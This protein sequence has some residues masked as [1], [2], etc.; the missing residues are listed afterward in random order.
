[1]DTSSARNAMCAL[2][3]AFALALP[4][5]RRS[6]QPP[7][8]VHSFVRSFVSAFPP[9]GVL[10]RTSKS[11]SSIARAT[12]RRAPVHPQRRQNARERRNALEC[13]DKHRAVDRISIE[14]LLPE[15]SERVRCVPRVVAFD[16]RAKDHWTRT[17]HT[18]TRFGRAR[19]RASA[20]EIA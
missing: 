12:A 11:P 15:R 9:N 4:C 1:M 18:S 7:S 2:K 6:P 3:R 14:Y 13:R 19:E 8:F 16:V 10:N 5:A 17:R 20:R